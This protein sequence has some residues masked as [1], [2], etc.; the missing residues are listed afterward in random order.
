MTT[1]A[2]L[3]DRIQ[4]NAVRIGQVWTRRD[5]EGTRVT[6]FEVI[7]VY[8]HGGTIRVTGRIGGGRLVKA[9]LRDMTMA[10]SRYALVHERYCKDDDATAT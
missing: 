7:N 10:N 2:C 3:S 8:E 4:N 5:P 6:E 9:R 1:Q